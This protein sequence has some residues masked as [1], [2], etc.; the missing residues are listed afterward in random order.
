M[1]QYP[2]ASE[3]DSPYLSETDRLKDFFRDLVIGTTTR[4]LS[5]SYAGKTYNMQYAAGTG[6]HSTDMFPS[7]VEKSLDFVVAG[8]LLNLDLPP[9]TISFS[10]VY[11]SYFTSFAMYGDPNVEIHKQEDMTFS[12]WPQPDNTRSEFLSPVLRA[13][14]HGFSIFLDV[15]NPRTRSDFWLN[16]IKELTTLGGY[17]S[18]GSSLP[19]DN[20]IANMESK[21]IPNKKGNNSHSRF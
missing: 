8:V 18:L 20:S 2:P 4:L 5:D 13:A 6:W 3:D 16:V 17:P 7:F 21:V 9:S 11:R 15:S 19:A 12:T 14:D 1:N 10:Q